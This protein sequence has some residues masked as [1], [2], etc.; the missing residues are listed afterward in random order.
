[1]TE[2]ENDMRKTIGATACLLLVIAA[3]PALALTPEELFEQRSLSIYVVHTYDKAGKKLGTGSA[4]AIG[5][6]QMITNCHVLAKAS[7]IAV[8][9]GNIT[10]G[11]TLEWPDPERDLCQLK[12]KDLPAPPVPF[13]STFK[14]RVGQRVF[15]IGAPRGLELTLSDGIVSSLRDADDGKPPVIQT[16]APSSPGSSGGGLFDA[17]GSLIGITTSGYLGLQL[18]FSMPVEWVRELPERGRAVLAKRKEAAE[19]RAAAA[20]AGPAAIAAL[21][22]IDPSLPKEMPQA[23]DTWTYVALDVTFNPG[24][25]SRKYVHTVR[26]VTR[27]SIVEVVMHQGAEVGQAAFTAD[28]SGIY[29]RG[30][31]VVE[32]A[33]FATAFRK[34]QP[35]EEWGSIKIQ[36]LEA[37]TAAAHGEVA[38]SFERGRVTGQ[39]RVTVAAGSFDALRIELDGR[40]SNIMIGG[41]AVMRGYSSFKQ[42]VWYAPEVKR[43][44]KVLSQGPRYTTAYELESYALR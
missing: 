3:T 43:I 33:P 16:T 30:A 15:A 5:R 6:E 28:M 39:E 1:M 19:A 21:A 32:F 12:V 17:D 23:G 9:R 10:L 25:R 38:Y 41:S 42:T 11:A 2:S 37:L 22:P 35:G 18:N 29:R 14:V 7:S 8:S 24:D 44:I 20:K 34:L 31:E 13:G 27:G 40:V 36:G 4:V 26:N